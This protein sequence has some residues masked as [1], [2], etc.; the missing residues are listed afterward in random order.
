MD[1]GREFQEAGEDM[2]RKDGSRRRRKPHLSMSSRG[3]PSAIVRGSVDQRSKE[4]RKCSVRGGV[5]MERASHGHA[6]YIMK[7]ILLVWH[8][9]QL[10]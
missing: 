8:P 3:I 7:P 2:I 5:D 1:A 10:Q 6:F 4:S 9:V